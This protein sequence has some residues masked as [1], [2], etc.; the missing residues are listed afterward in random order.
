MNLLNDIEISKLWLILSKGAINYSMRNQLLFAEVVVLP[1]QLR[2][3]AQ[4]QGDYI[5][6]DDTSN[7]N[8]N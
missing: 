6:R 5:E 3:N 8:S 1:K 2:V 7:G 4:N